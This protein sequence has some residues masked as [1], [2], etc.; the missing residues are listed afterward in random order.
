MDCDCFIMFVGYMD[1]HFGITP[2]C[3]KNI[4]Y[5]IQIMFGS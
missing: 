5:H 4:S 1:E 3:E 2:Y